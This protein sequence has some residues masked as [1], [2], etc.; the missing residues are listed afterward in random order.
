MRH[1]LNGRLLL[2]GGRPLRE[3]A[4]PDVAD[5]AYAHLMRNADPKGRARI[6]AIIAGLPDPYPDEATPETAA[7]AASEGSSALAALN[8]MRRAMG[9]ESVTGLQQGLSRAPNTPP[10]P[11]FDPAA[12]KMPSQAAAMTEMDLVNQMRERM[13]KP[14]VSMPSTPPRGGP[15]T[16]RI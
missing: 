13:G 6:D 9:Q 10:R 1:E 12:P 5:M 7:Q 16:V 2:A 4:A 14:R 11:R 3:H 8:D 15:G